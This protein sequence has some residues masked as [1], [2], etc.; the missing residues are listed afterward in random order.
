MM[1][2]IKYVIIAC[3][4]C[5]WCGCYQGMLFEDTFLDDEDIMLYDEKPFKFDTLCEKTNG[6][7]IWGKRRYLDKREIALM[8]MLG[9]ELIVKES[10]LYNMSYNLFIKLEKQGLFK[11]RFGIDATDYDK[12]D[13]R[14][15][16]DGYYD[17]RERMIFFCHES[18]I[19]SERVLLHELL[20]VFQCELATVRPTVNN[21]LF[22]EYEV[23]MIYDIIQQRMR[24]DV[25]IH[26]E[27]GND[28]KVY[29]DFIR[30][31]ALGNY[32]FNKEL[33]RK[34][35]N[36][37]FKEKYSGVKPNYEPSFLFYFLGGR[38]VN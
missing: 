26:L 38:V 24:G 22:M 15:G 8:S 27:G 29:A 3:F 23:L 30:E 35:F 2:N 16:K 4:T 31:A 10:V 5:L 7:T 14:W 36:D 20:H 34:L 21:E 9:Q 11:L 25:R 13:Y 37:F 18:L 6:A 32:T 1:K 17:S 12:T 33:L 28:N 19:M